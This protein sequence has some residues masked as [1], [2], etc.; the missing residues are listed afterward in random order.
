MTTYFNP[1]QPFVSFFNA[2]KAYIEANIDTDIYEI[3]PSY[4]DVTEMTKKTPFPKTLIHFDI[5]DPQQRFFGF[6]DNIVDSQYVEYDEDS[7]L[8]GTVIESEA[9]CHEVALDFG[10]WASIE[11]GGPSARLSGRDDLDRIFNGPQA[12]AACLAATDG[13]DVMSFT[14]GRNFT[15]KI[16]DLTVFRMVGIEL[17]IKFYSRKRNEP[18]PFLDTIVQNP[19]LTVAP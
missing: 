14:G 11:N 12:R 4:P 1:D 6:G 8:A 16:N 18:G 17:R 5:D 2:L 3:V 9:H 7:D 19:T 10:I 13:L 15:D